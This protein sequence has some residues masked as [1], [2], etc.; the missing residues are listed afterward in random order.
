MTLN[1]HQILYGS[2]S[3]LPEQ[4]HLHAGP[5]TAL[6]EDGTLRHIK[7]GETLIL[8]QVY[9][10]VR[11]HNWETVPA[12]I[13]DLQIA[14]Q[15]DSFQIRFVSHHQQAHIDFVWRA[16]ITGSADGTIRFD[17]DGHA[18]STFQRNRIGFCV[19]HPTNCAGQACRVEH[20]DGSMTE[21]QF[22]AHIS[23]H[24]PF[25]NIRAITHHINGVGV[26]VLMEGDTFEMED[27]RN[28]TDASYK[29]YCTPLGLPFP[30]TVNNGDRIQQTITLSLQGDLPASS[31]RENSMVTIQVDETPTGTIP[32]I[33]LGLPDHAP[34]L[35][36][37]QVKRLSA[38][39]LGHLRIDLRLNYGDW[40]V[41]L[42]RA[43][44]QAE[45]LNCQLEVALHLTDDA[46][47]ELQV[48]KQY[49]KSHAI[50]VA[51]WIIFHQQE[52]STSAQWVELARKHLTSAPIGAG[53]NAFFTEL[54]RQRP[55]VEQIDFAIY[56]TNPQVHA[57][58]NLSLVE[59][60]AIHADNID[61]ARQFC[62]GKPIIVSPITFKMRFNPNATGEAP[63]VLE[64]ELPP[65]VDARQMSLFGACWT[66]GSLKYHL[67]SQIGSV[68]YFETVGWRGIMEGAVT[69]PLPDKFPSLTNSV[70]PMYHVFADLGELAGAEIVT[71]HSSD[72]LKADSLVLRHNN[73]FTILIANMSP[74]TQTIRLNVPAGHYTLRR[75]NQS[76]ALDAMTQPEAYRAQ[77]HADF[78]V[79]E[80]MTAIAL[81]PYEY[82]RLQEG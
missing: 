59:T 33:G 24:Q 29:T 42:N 40:Q 46:D 65:E 67:E 63:P 58:D 44:K 61:S 55:P 71:S 75:L 52:K 66:L 23:P 78:E 27:Q 74:D 28:W 82:I 41:R 53:T 72:H 22:P 73:K 79:S 21:G 35:T 7:L 56:S 4:V 36:A 37:L 48:L 45:Q 2:N 12:Q 14:A 31:S 81:S 13:S 64:G 10:A 26:R 39:Q 16:E 32:P 15:D 69:P 49:A 50:P 47:Q 8:H 6:F 20:V 9:A 1:E 70:F 18:N 3:P 25:F 38:L 60:L 68:T 17:F 19:L 77:P 57:F 43:I 51:R 54:N 30:V 76:N 80:N 5:L 11:D 62:G 34:E